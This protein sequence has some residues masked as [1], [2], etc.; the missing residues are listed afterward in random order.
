MSGDSRNIVNIKRKILNLSVF[1]RVS[2]LVMLQSLCMLCFSQSLHASN[3]IDDIDE[4]YYV[5]FGLGTSFLKPQTNN[6]ALTISQNNDSGYK[7]FAGYQFDNH[8][9]AELFLAGL[10]KA[11]IRSQSTGNVVGFIE[12]QSFGVRGLYQYPVNESWNVFASAGIAHLQNEFQFLNVESASDDLVYGGLGVLWNIAESWD[13]RAEYD[14]YNGDVQMLSINIVKHFG[15]GKN[16]RIVALEQALSEAE[17]K[18]SENTTVPIKK[19]KTC[20]GFGIDFEGV[21]FERGLI[22][23]N[24]VA[25][26]RLDKLALKLLKLPEDITFEIRAHTDDT[27]TEEYNYRLSLA[28]G[29]VVRDYLSAHGIALS[30]IEVHGYGEWSQKQDDNISYGR[31]L[32]RRAELE[33]VGV[34]K[35]VEDTS[36][37]TEKI[38]P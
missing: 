28:R 1:T 5:G 38:V 30:R 34:E 35:Y 2:L 27:G 15:F 37:C 25:R 10:G 7:M 3:S 20:E 36:T 24:A 14:V 12:Y 21:I 18:L 33:L 23:L 16:K 26:Q 8:W 11:N 17:I 6:T 4:P 32:S 9:A 13:L 22:E 29:R 19:Q 31:A